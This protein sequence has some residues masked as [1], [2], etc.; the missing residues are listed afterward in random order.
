VREGAG[1]QNLFTI[2]KLGAI[3]VLVTG[4]LLAA[5][6]AAVDW[7][8]PLPA[9]P[10]ALVVPFGFALI[11]TLWTYDGWFAVTFQAGEMRQPARDLPR[12]LLLGVAIV[13][14]AYAL[15]NLVYLRALGIER[16]AGTTRAA[17]VAARAFWGDGA[18]RAMTAAVAVSAFGCLA[19]TILYSSRIYQP[20]AADGVFF[21]GVARI[22]PRWRTPV[23]ALWLQSAWAAALTLTGSYT[24]LFTYVTF[25]GVLFHVAAGLAVFRLRV[26]RPIDHRPYRAWGWPVVPGLFVLGM[27]LLTLNTLLAAPR[28][29]LWGLVAIA[30]G[31]P[32]YIYWRKRAA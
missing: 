6:K 7:S 26:T 12:G 18:A 29:S 16:F 30:S 4:G 13:V 2:A 20:M 17:E 32:A 9:A 15:L 19:A 31:I 3:A 5:P 14:L 22:H 10:L 11:A 8:A 27:A 1:V 24:Q 28:E 23:A 25:G 21:R